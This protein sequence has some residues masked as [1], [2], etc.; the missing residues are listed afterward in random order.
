MKLAQSINGL[1]LRR[2]NF[3]E[4]AKTGRTHPPRAALV[5]IDGSGMETMP[6]VLKLYA[7]ATLDCT[8]GLSS[9][10]AAQ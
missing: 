6:H 1:I 8:H 7:P 4:P 9:S 3:V 10:N 2:E 5:A